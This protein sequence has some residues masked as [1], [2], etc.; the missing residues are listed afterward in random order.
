M[1]R[2]FRINF[3]FNWSIALLIAVELGLLAFG[4][5]ALVDTL[6]I[7]APRA[8][9]RFLA[10]FVVW[11]LPGASVLIFFRPRKKAAQPVRS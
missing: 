3:E 1:V 6:L 9:W 2:N 11:A 8:A 10:L 5:W 4:V 7:S